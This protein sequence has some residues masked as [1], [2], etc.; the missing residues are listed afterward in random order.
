MHVDILNASDVRQGPGPIATVKRWQY[1]QRL[2]QAGEWQLDVP[3]TEP[4]L[5]HATVK[6]RLYGYDYSAGGQQWVGGGT[7]ERRTMTIQPN[8]PP[9]MSLS[10]ND[11]LYELARV[12]VRLD[13]SWNSPYLGAALY[14]KILEGA[15]G[16]TVTVDGATPSVVARFADESILNALVLITNKTGQMFRLD[17]QLQFDG[18]IDFRH[19]RIFSA[20]VPSGIVA[21]KDAAPMAI[22]R[23]T[24]ACLIENITRQEDAWQL[25]N[26]AI[27]Y[28]AGAGE[29]QFT[30]W[31]A[32]QWPDGSGIG[33]PYTKTDVMGR[34]HTFTFDKVAN[35]ITDQESVA[36]Y[37]TSTGRV[38]FKEIV[39]I[40][41][42]EFDTIAAANA[43]VQATTE[44]LLNASRQQDHYALSVGRLRQPVYPGQ[45]IHV[46]AQEWRDGEAPIDIDEHLIIQE[47]TT[48]FTPDGIRPVGLVVA[49]SREFA[50]TD[51]QVVANAI[52]QSLVYQA[53]PQTGP[54]ENT[55]GYREEIDYETGAVFPFW[56]SRGTTQIT[57]VIARFTLSKLR[58][59]VKT[60]GGTVEATVS[61]EPHTHDI[62][63]DDHTHPVPNHNHYF[64]I[65]PGSVGA[66]VQV[67]SG[68]GSPD[69]GSLVGNGLG[70]Q[71]RI[72]TNPATGAVTSGGGGST[73]TSSAEGGGAADIPIDISS[74]ISASYGIY[75]DPDPAYG[76]NDLIWSVNGV[77]VA[78]AP[79]VIE[80]D[81][82]EL[83]ITSYIINADTLTPTNLANRMAVQV[84]PSSANDKKVRVTWQVEIRS[85][86][87]SLRIV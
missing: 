37:G 79:A 47:V 74:G 21:I 38:A 46:V 11:V 71:I 51:A 7:I 3:A 55:M 69:V 26:R 18:T 50:M 31:A 20:I 22:E 86:I 30:A 10:G 2:S 33:G 36:E 12:T 57:T 52:Q 73:E 25:I 80:D 48:A 83:D 32:L 17:P 6:R 81:W 56:L 39:P 77:T 49:T 15:P 67:F 13:I 14:T 60:V 78:A 53:H 68:G 72:A 54:S 35:S 84:N 65:D 23:N 24:N 87:Q 43:L 41:N 42:G 45:S 5:A 19:I 61:F 85:N 62:E 1:A 8:K 63:L 64:V 40:S 66:D 59:T 75:E 4:R 34:V 16:W 70:G 27:P 82:Y 29:S 44:W 58:S 28:G 76:I 9:D